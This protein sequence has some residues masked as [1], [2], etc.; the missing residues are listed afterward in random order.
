[1][2]SVADEMIRHA[3]LPILLVR[4]GDEPINLGAEPLPVRVLVPLDGTDL[5]EQILEPAVALADMLPGME[6]ILLRVVKPLVPI[7]EMPDGPANL[8]A[9]HILTEVQV[10]QEQLHRRAETYLRDI[11]ARL[12]ARGLKVEVRVVVSERPEEAILHEAEKT[13]ASLIALET[14]GRSGLSR[15][16]KGSVADKVVRGSH[17]PVMVQRPVTV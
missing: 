5:A 14:H 13:S 12:E 2:G 3:H 11:A 7:A 1:M 15:L 6:Y 16:V 8:E 9:H 4:P 10:I 17:V